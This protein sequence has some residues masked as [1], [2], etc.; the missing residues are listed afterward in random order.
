MLGGIILAKGVYIFRGIQHSCA[1]S[2]VD[3]TRLLTITLNSVLEE[4]V[5]YVS[6]YSYI[7]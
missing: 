7:V 3:I 1:Y 6:G 5:C 4:L 2:N